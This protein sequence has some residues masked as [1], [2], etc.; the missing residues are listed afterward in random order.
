MNIPSPNF[1][2]DT[3]TGWPDELRFL[4]DRYPREVWPDHVNL[5]EMA[6]FWLQIHDGFR[7]LGGAIRT[8]TGEFR[9]GLMKPEEFRNWFAPRL[10][11]LLTHLNGHHQIED[12]QFFPLFSAAEPRL[13]RGFEVLESD[14]ESIHAAIGRT[15]ESANAL[16]HASLT[17]ADVLHR[18]GDAYAE[19]NEALLARLDRHL[20]DEEDLI[21]P[22]I[23]ERGEGP[24]GM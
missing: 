23:L 5:G 11:T 20:G 21:I 6:Q 22:L 1:D 24:L 14:H 10:Q 16:L 18:L 17:D 7:D 13:A 15:V 8:K 9:Q 19:T 2:L 3:R 12:H 4:F